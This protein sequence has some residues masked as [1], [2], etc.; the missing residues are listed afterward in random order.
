MASLRAKLLI[1]ATVLAFAPA[2]VSDDS[3]LEFKWVDSRAGDCHLSGTLRLHPDGHAVFDATSWTDQSNTG[4]IWHATLHVYNAQKQ[5]LFGFGVWDSPRMF[6]GS[7]YNWKKEGGF[8]AG[9]FD[10]VD[11]ADLG[12]DC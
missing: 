12:G 6:P 3:P 2:L 9:L 7:S 1:A 11:S 10:Q 4:D 5:E 8:P